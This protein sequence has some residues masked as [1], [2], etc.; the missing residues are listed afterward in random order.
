MIYHKFIIQLIIHMSYH[1]THPLTWFS[2]NIILELIIRMSY[3]ISHPFTWYIILELIIHVISYHTPTFTIIDV[4]S[5]MSLLSMSNINNYY[6]PQHHHMKSA[7]TLSYQLH[8]MRERVTA[9]KRRRG[10][11]KEHYNILNKYMQVSNDGCDYG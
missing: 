9:E 8:L 10:K 7:Q 1:I 5:Q 2:T 11:C 4:I 3:H 6:S